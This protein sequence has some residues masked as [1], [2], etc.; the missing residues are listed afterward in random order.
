MQTAVDTPLQIEYRPT[1]ADFMAAYKLQVKRSIVSRAFHIANPIL[2]SFIILMAVLPP[3]EHTGPWSGAIVPLGIGL[4]VLFCTKVWMRSRSSRDPRMGQLITTSFNDD[5]IMVTGSAA[6]T[7]LFWHGV[8]DVRENK[9]IILFALGPCQTE[10][11]PKRAF[12]PGQLQRL[13]ELIASKG[14]KTK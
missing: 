11:I 7:E 2:G 13:R 5:A 10:C 14:L 9:D 12:A 3:L 6:R 1:L 8:T 4:F